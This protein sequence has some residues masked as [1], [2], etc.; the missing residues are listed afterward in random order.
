MRNIDY[1]IIR[2]RE[3]IEAV[4][5]LYRQDYYKASYRELVR[6]IT[7]LNELNNE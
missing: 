4:E 1:K 6:L 2:G 3:L 7:Q 5:K